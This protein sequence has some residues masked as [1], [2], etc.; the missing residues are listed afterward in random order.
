[1][2]RSNELC[3]DIG[4]SQARTAMTQINPDRS[5]RPGNPPDAVACIIRHQQRAI[6]V[7]HQTRRA[8]MGMLAI[9]AS[10]PATSPLRAIDI[11]ALLVRAD[12]VGPAGDPPGAE[13][14]ADD[15]V[16]ALELRPEPLRS[17]LEGD[18]SLDPSIGW[19]IARGGVA[20]AADIARAGLIRRL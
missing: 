8:A 3:D 1:M 16:E 17:A 14:L 6:L 15:A 12:L 7:H 20:D 11:A 4:H 2:V 10:E 5:A 18:A 9:A 19:G 13:H